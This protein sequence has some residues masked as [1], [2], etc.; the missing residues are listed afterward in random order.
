MKFCVSSAFSDA[1]QLGAIA[2]AADE[3]GFHAIGIPDHVLN[4]VE[5]ASPYPYTADGSRRWEP[6]TH[7]PDPWVTIGFLAGQTTQLHFFT[8]IYV[9]PMRPPVAV[10]KAVSTAAA[11]SGGRVALGVGMGWMEEEFAAMEQP[12]RRRGARADEA[13][14][15]IRALWTGEVV[16]HHGGH[17]DLPASEMLPRPPTRIPIWVGGLSEPALRRAARHD[18]W[19]SDLHTAEELVGLRA[20]LDTYR[21][22]IGRAGEPFAF[23]AACADAFDL[24]GYRRLADAGVTHLMTLPW[25]LEG[26]FTASL[27]A[28]VDSLHRFGDEVLTRW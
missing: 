5:I 4:P 27:G 26:G 21:A 12:F 8:N 7:W 10:A 9:L 25:V 15:L 13:L 2:R 14:E 6:G 17:F 1:D 22:E 11:L 3:A 19:I 20:R 18:G 28:K 16:E 23:V 24:D